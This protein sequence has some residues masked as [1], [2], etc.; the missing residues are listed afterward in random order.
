MTVESVN[1]KPLAS[2]WVM[3]QSVEGPQRIDLEPKDG[4][5]LSWSLQAGNS[6]LR[7]IRRE[8][9]YEIQVADQDGLSLEIPIRGTIRIRPDEL[10]TIVAD[11]LHKVVLPTAEPAIRYR[12]TDDYG[13]AKIALV[14]SV[15]RSSAKTIP[16]A[17]NGDSAADTGVPAQPATAAPAELHRFELH[18]GS[19]PLVGDRLPVAGSF[20]LSLSQLKL[21]KG[22]SLKLTLEVTDYRGENEQGQPNGQSTLSDSLVLQVSDESGV[23]AA[24]AEGDLRSEQ[25]LSEIIKRQLGIGDQ[26]Q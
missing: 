6:P 25:Q 12:A 21:S 19:A 15:E 26:P 23:L 24:I 10:P 3:L 2:A 7:D 14:V 22:D 11:V 17:A 20:P 4:Q 9:R 18:A 16:S 8:L 1:R 13:I 5:R